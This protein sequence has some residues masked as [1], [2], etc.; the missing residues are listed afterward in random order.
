MTKQ[1]KAR[2]H[3]ARAHELL[4]AQDTL[5][6][7]AKRARGAEGPNHNYNTRLRYKQD[8][9]G[10]LKLPD[11]VITKMITDGMLDGAQLI[12]MMQVGNDNL[13]RIIKDTLVMM[14]KRYDDNAIFEMYSTDDLNM[15]YLLVKHGDK[16]AHPDLFDLAIV[17]GNRDLVTAL[18]KAGED[19]NQSL[20][21]DITTPLSWAVE[22]YR[23]DIAKILIEKG[24]DVNKKVRDY[25]NPSVYITPLDLAF[26]KYLS[27]EANVKGNEL[28]I[29]KLLL[30]KGADPKMMTYLSQRRKTAS[31]MQRDLQRSDQKQN[32]LL[33]LILHAR[34]GTA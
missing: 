1:Q 21:D 17:R 31:F 22:L 32:Q 24:A 6:F 11:D 19:V 7:G 5:A 8:M 26:K 28:D 10:L 9:T 16:R 3:L 2:A 23:Y 4:N 33:F 30:K 12:M 25:E 18:L 14:S 34:E 15:I 20:D 13:N 29:V 27:R